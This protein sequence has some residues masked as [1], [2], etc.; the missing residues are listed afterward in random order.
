MVSSSRIAGLAIVAGLAL[1]PVGLASAQETPE[2]RVRLTLIRASTS[3]G[4]IDPAAE[5]LYQRL[6]KQ[7]FRY[8]SL[9]VIKK[10]RLRMAMREERR[11]VLPTGGSLRLRPL[12]RR[13][14]GLMI[15]LAIEGRLDTR[16]MLR[17]EKHVVIGAG[18]IEGGQLIVQIESD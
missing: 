5:V 17:P 8:Q 15:K 16:I 18:P 14:K 2:V 12:E 7:Q 6:Q 1:L 13:P 11:V 3:P 9:R 10:H 4:P